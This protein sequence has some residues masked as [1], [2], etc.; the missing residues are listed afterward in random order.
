M[1]FASW[2]A[3]AQ[4]AGLTPLSVDCSAPILIE[5]FFYV[6][7]RL[8]VSVEILPPS[9]EVSR[10]GAV[11]SA[12]ADRCYWGAVLLSLLTGRHSLSFA[13]AKDNEPG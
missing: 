6:K 8:Y 2:R 10:D 7:T 11:T 12:A 3:L 1:D 5:V 9:S 13:A 4:A